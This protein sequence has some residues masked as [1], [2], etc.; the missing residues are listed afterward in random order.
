MAS[1]ARWLAKLAALVAILLLAAC[2]T[3][4]QKYAA[5][6]AFLNASAAQKPKKVLLLPPDIEVMEI[7]AGGVPEKVEA[8]G[9]QAKANIRQSLNKTTGVTRNFELIEL[10]ELTATE[11]ETVEKFL[12]FYDVVGGTAF[13]YGRSQDPAWQHKV[14]NFDYTLGEG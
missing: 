3:P 7:S 9:K 11:K 4:P 6:P 12:A 14:Q 5:S 1:Q 10:P 2:A 13:F 8:W